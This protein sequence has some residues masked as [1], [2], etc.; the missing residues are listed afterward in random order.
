L[1]SLDPGKPPIWTVANIFRQCPPDRP[2][3]KNRLGRFQLGSEQAQR[4]DAGR[5][6][7]C[8]TAVMDG[9]QRPGNIKGIDPGAPPIWTLGDLIS[10][11]NAGF[12]MLM[13]KRLAGI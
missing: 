4:L 13:P 8:Q 3:G 12:R 6:R 5:H 11:A 10:K 9:G 7:S 2:D 1:A